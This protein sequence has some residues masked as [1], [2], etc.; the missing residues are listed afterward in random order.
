VLFR[1]D[2]PDAEAARTKLAA[3]LKKK[4]TDFFIVK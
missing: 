2:K 1:S 3:A 4:R